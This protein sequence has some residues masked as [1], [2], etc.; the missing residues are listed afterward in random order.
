MK[1]FAKKVDEGILQFIQFVYIQGGPKKR[2]IFF[3]I[4]FFTQMRYFDFVF[5]YLCQNDGKVY[6]ENFKKFEFHLG[7]HF[8]KTDNVLNSCFAAKSLQKH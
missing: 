2:P 7:G 6:P 3:W 8:S 5:T 4:S 1:P